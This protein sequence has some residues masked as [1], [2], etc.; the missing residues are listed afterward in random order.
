[1]EDVVIVCNHQ[2]QFLPYLGFFHKVAH[3]DLVVLLDDVQFM[4]RHFQHRNNIKHQTGTQL[5]TVP[6]VKQRGQLIKDVL[7]AD[8]KWRRAMWA[9]IQ[10]SYGKAP[11]FRELAPGL[12]AIILEGTHTR[13]V[14]LDVELLQWAMGVLDI[15]R[16]M[17]LSSQLGLPPSTGPNEHHIAICKAVGAD[18][19]LSGPGGKEYMDNAKWD[20]AGVSVRWQAYTMREYVQ[21]FAQHGFIPN[22]AVIDA[23]FNLGREARA[24]VVD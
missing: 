9:A 11:H 21:L 2:P 8:V 4:D 13:L 16:P 15:V 14:P 23:L 19:Y 1:V 24:L 7:L 22:L 6:V 10:S 12:Q 3:S 17:R 18:A 5:L 20:A